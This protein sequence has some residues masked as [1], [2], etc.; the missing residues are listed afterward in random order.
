MGRPR[1]SD[2]GVAVR[3]RIRQSDLSLLQE[4]AKEQGNNI[5]EL[6]RSIL[7]DYLYD[8]KKARSMS[9]NSLDE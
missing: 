2:P 9:T 4:I 1:L 7:A 3:V 6:Y 5:S 8:Y